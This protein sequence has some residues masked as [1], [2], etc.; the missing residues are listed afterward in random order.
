VFAYIYAVLNCPSYQSQYSD[1]LKLDFPR[2]RLVPRDEQFVEL[3]SLGTKLIRA[4]LVCSPDPP[5]I[6]VSFPVTGDNLVEK[7]APR[8]VEI[9][10]QNGEYLEQC[11]VYINKNQYFENVPHEVWE[12]DI[13]GYQVL[14]QWL[15]DRRG[16]ELSYDDLN[17]YERMV[18]AVYES[19]QI[20]DE[21]DAVVPSWSAAT[22]GTG[23]S[24][25][26]ETNPSEMVSV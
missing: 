2:V 8:F 16:E 5:A 9:N 13:G 23:P 25:V 18:G 15:K 12:A 4:H 11:R 3:V 20:I 24:P 6:A 1:V 10:P 22:A 14:S 21:L 26:Y 17:H 7:E 19:I